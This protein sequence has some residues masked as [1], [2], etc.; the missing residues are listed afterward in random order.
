MMAVV[1]P[2]HPAAHSKSGWSGEERSCVAGLA[3]RA[4]RQLTA[5]GG[6]RHVLHG[7]GPHA[8]DGGLKAAPRA[9][10]ARPGGKPAIALVGVN[11]SQHRLRDEGGARQGAERSG[12]AAVSRSLNART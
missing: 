6:Y 9:A 5:G 3:K 11:I 8:G 1:H 10:R 12:P 2:L 4:V 7:P